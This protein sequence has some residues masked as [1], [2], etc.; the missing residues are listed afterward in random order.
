MFSVPWSK[1]VESNPENKIYVAITG[2]G[3]FSVYMKNM[4][5]LVTGLLIWSLESCIL[6]FFLYLFSSKWLF[7]F[8]IKTPIFKLWVWY[9]TKSDN[10]RLIFVTNQGWLEIAIYKLPN[11]H[12]QRKIENFF[13]SFIILNSLSLFQARQLDVCIWH[14]MRFNSSVK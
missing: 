8:I 6:L 12:I 1:H 4:F 5:H 11:G 14:Q 2:H 13:N 7:I 3:C 9:D 10:S